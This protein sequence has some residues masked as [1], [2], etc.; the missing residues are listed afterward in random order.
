VQAE[1]R[2]WLERPIDPNNWLMNQTELEFWMDALARR[3]DKGRMSFWMDRIAAR[4]ELAPQGFAP[5]RDEVAVLS[6]ERERV[7]AMPPHRSTAKK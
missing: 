7:M 2:Y 6:A 3:G 1:L 4:S 5:L